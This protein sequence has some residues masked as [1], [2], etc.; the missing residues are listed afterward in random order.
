MAGL[1][2]R[3]RAVAVTVFALGCVLML[4]RGP[5]RALTRDS[6]DSVLVYAAARAWLS[7]GNPYEAE[8]VA[9]AWRSGGGPSAVDPMASR[10]REVL[11]YPPTALAVLSPWAA[12][13]WAVAAPVWVVG[14]V[15]LM[16]VVILGAAGLAGLRRGSAAWWWMMAGGVWLAPFHTCITLGQTAILVTACVVGGLVARA[17]GRRG[18]AGVLMGIGAAVKPQLAG[19]FL[20]YEAGRLRGKVVV[21]GGVAVAVLTVIGI[22]RMEVGGAGAWRASWVRNVREFAAGGDGRPTADNPIRH[23][24]V[25][26]HYPLHELTDHRPLVTWAVFGIVGALCAVYAWVDWRAR[27]V[28]REEVGSEELVSLSMVAVATLLVVYHRFYD[29]TV[30][31]LPLAMA[32][33]TMAA[34]VGRSRWVPLVLMAPFFVNS[35]VALAEVVKRGV[36]PAGLT[37]TGFWDV[38]V[39][40]HQVWA[41]LALGLWLLARR[42]RPVQRISADSRQPISA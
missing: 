17:S 9:A 27:R 30:L 16:G 11:V 5:V 32:V 18:L 12:L 3:S 36:I 39:M 14:N 26:L 37:R 7:G 29:A 10:T 21:W 23:H 38:V 20:V 35:A 31:V 24:L 13:P 1:S 28:G 33:G 22:G 42:A 6:F 40:P 25:N 4:Y 2:G 19:L 34:G 15:A 41:L 8:P